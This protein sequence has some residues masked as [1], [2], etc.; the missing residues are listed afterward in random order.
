MS[1]KQKF[2]SG[3]NVHLSGMWFNQP[4]L[5]EK[6]TKERPFY[7]HCLKHAICTLFAKNFIL[8]R[9]HL[10]YVQKCTH[11]TERVIFTLP[12]DGS[13]WERFESQ[14]FEYI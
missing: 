13:Q 14:I 8:P 6:T 5:S 2:S 11:E 4:W 3:N 7:V 1:A 10:Q 12:F 9:K